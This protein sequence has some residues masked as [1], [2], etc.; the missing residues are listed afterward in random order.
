[1]NHTFRHF[2]IGAE[3]WVGSGRRRERGMDISQNVL[4]YQNKTDGIW[5][6]RSPERKLLWFWFP[7]F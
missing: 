7:V 3:G 6:S 5:L 1:M 2:R 4:M